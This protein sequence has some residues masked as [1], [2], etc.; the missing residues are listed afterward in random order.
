MRPNILFILVDSLRSD[1]CFGNNKS[2]Y[3]P[4]LDSLLSKGCYFKNTFASADGTII[5]LN[6]TFNSKFQ[7]ETG[8]RARKL[9]LLEDNHMETLRKSGY[10][11]AGLIPNLTSLKPLEEYFE[12]DDC[13]F[14][15]GPPYVTL[16]TG[17]TQRI[18]SLLNSLKNK[19]P[20]FCYIHLFDLHPLREGN[21]PSKIEE[22]RTKQFGDSLYS[23]TVSS[24]DYNLKIIS[25]QIN[26]NDTLLV[27]TADHGERIPYDDKVSFQFEPELKSVKSI[28]K[29]ILPHAAHNTSG[30]LFGKIKKSIGN[31]KANQSN[32]ELNNYEKRSR[33]PYFTLSLY[34]ELL[35]IPLFISGLNLKSKIISNQVS[36]LQI[37]PT[38]LSLVGINYKKTKYNESLVKLFDGNHI[39]EKEI[40]LHTI[41]YEKKS[42][43][44]RIGIRT[45][46]FKYFRNSSEPTKDLHLYDLENDPYENNN[47]AENNHP[48]VQKM[49]LTLNDIQKHSS[50][51][52]EQLSEEEDKIISEEL[53]K[54][55]YL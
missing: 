2:S 54:L 30:K 31:V 48:I 41:P 19:E 14:D 53:K 55:G 43:L 40:F 47:I 32:R 49:E 36:T 23:Q 33:D 5:S 26:F 18:M 44:D 17:M 34:D 3:T 6:C 12:N 42:T 37:F 8:V 11:L 46:A 7:S 38:I 20:W 27:L 9:I 51:L 52:E 29:K 16:P 35:H 28:G 24:I 39:E 13:T 1:Q 45:S 21:V 50:K 15:K 4:F 25:E 10:Y 22:F